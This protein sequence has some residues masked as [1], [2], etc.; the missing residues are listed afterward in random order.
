[1]NLLDLLTQ[2]GH[3]LK[4]KTANEYAGPC[5]FCMG[6]DRFI[7]QVNHS[8]G[9]RYW[10]RQ[11]KKSG[12]SIQYLR[13]VKGLSYFEA[14]EV[15]CVTPKTSNVQNAQLTTQDIYAWEPSQVE[16]PKDKWKQKA[17]AFVD[18]CID[19]LWG[20]YGRGEP[21]TW[22][23]ESAEI[24]IWLKEVR[25][26]SDETI[27]KT[28]LGWNP[29]DYYWARESWG[30]PTMMNQTTG[31]PKELW[32]PK[33][34][35]I[36]MFIGAEIIKVKFRRANLGQEE[37]D[38]YIPI[39]GGS[40]SP[41]IFQGENKRVVSV[42]ESELDGILIWQKARDLVTCIALGSAQS[43]PDIETDEILRQSE[44]ILVSLDSDEA[45]AR[46][47]WRWWD[48]H[49]E[50]VKRWPC[51]RGKDPAEMHQAGIDVRTWI[52]AGLAE[53]KERKSEIVPPRVN[54]RQENEKKAVLRSAVI[55]EKKQSLRIGSVDSVPRGAVSCPIIHTDPYRMWRWEN[56]KG[57]WVCEICHPHPGDNSNIEFS[58]VTKPVQAQS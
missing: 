8:N 15:L 39:A 53:K 21:S 46:E 52:K 2:N 18:R 33:G 7:V 54:Q 16:V 37:K 44:L 22:R 32:A 14:C 20:K 4:R 50:N 47:A 10:C 19:N 6:S 9:G 35:V 48:E 55:L 25:G 31:R 58:T 45:G 29:R 28:G 49:Y 34:L 5:P 38:R 23:Q 43:R 27:I 24:R 36:P 17:K 56:G 57:P 12:D 40:K 41:M 11:C 1:M 13:D 42:V 51:V 26:L 30:L 3:E